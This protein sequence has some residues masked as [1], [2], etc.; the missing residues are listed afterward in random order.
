MTTAG[1]L[2]LSLVSCNTQP[3][4]SPR[5]QTSATAS[6]GSRAVADVTGVSDVKEPT[7]APLNPVTTSRAALPALVA[8]SDN[9]RGRLRSRG[10]TTPPVPTS[11]G[12]TTTVPIVAPS[13]AV[14]TT[15]PTPRVTVSAPDPEAGRPVGV[16][17]LIRATWPED[18]DRAVRIAKCESGG[19]VDAVGPGDHLGLMQIAWRVW[20]KEAAKMGYSRADL[21]TAGPNLALARRI[22]DRAGGSFKPW[23]CR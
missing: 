11:A 7:G 13:R 19:R 12:T 3:N 4:N 16:E 18:P 1:L 10:A 14:P 22:Y 20:A 17:A 9:G 8:P 23:S 15:S 21:L 6:W 5:Q 2:V